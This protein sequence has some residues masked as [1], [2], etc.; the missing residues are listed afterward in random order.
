MTTGILS[1][2]KEESP[3]KAGG[4]TFYYLSSKTPLRK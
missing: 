4:K 1:I 3:V 2:D